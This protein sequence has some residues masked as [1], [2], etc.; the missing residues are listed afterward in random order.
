MS[1]HIEKFIEKFTEEFELPLIVK[2]TDN[3][4][5]KLVH[6]NA[7]YVL[8]ILKIPNG[9]YIYCGCV[10][11]QKRRLD[12]D[13]N[14]EDMDEAIAKI[15][16]HYNKQLRTRIWYNLEKAGKRLNNTPDPS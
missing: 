10:S 4:H 16:N 6:K 8:H 15:L 7:K 3:K 2:K 1:R 9:L 13:F 11:L 12:L 14:I 5:Y